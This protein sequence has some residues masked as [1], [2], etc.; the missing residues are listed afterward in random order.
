MKTKLIKLLTV[1]TLAVMC[2]CVA[3]VS[4]NAAAYYGDIDMDGN[5]S[6]SDA[7]KVL[8]HSAKIQLLDDSLFARA[9]VNLDKK[10]TASDAR[11]ILRVAAKLDEFEEY[12]DAVIDQ[13]ELAEYNGIKA[14]KLPY[15]IDGLKIESIVY[16]AEKSSIQMVVRNNTGYAVERLSYIT[17]KCYDPINVFINERTVSVHNMNKNEACLLTFYIHEDTAKIVFY[18]A[19]IKK[20]EFVPSSEMVEVDGMNVNKMPLNLNGIVI[21]SISFDK[22]YKKAEI[23][24]SNET[25]YPVSSL[26]TVLYKT[27]NSDGYIVTSKGIYL[28]EMN[29]NEKAI[30]SFY[31]DESVSDFVFYASDLRKSESLYQGEMVDIGGF[32]VNKMPY[33]L[34]GICLEN[35]VYNSK[36]KTLNVTLRNDH[37]FAISDYSYMEYKV[38]NAENFVVSSSNVYTTHL[39]SKESC[40]KSISL[41]EGA[42][43]VVFGNA[44][45]KETETLTSDKI[46]VYDGVEVT[47]LPYVTNGLRIEEVVFGDYNQIK[48]KIRNTTGNAITANSFINYKCYN[49][50][51]VVIRCGLFTTYTLNNNESQIYSAYLPENT[52]KIVFLNSTVKTGE[53][54]KNYAVS[55]VE[56]MLFNTCPVNINGL[57]IEKVTVAENSDC[58]YLTI[59][60]NTGK[61]LTNN[62]YILYNCYD[63]DGNVVKEGYAYL[64]RLNKYNETQVKIRVSDTAVKTVVFG[65]KIYSAEQ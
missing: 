21:N 4:A 28:E 34:N 33:S 18:K 20:C 7:R 27:Y 58:Y 40:L 1:I 16:D 10:I 35:A 54:K 57:T 61:N 26:S 48:I 5:V 29:N 41:P 64:D 52:A 47:S 51:G 49:P 19:D 15:E 3:A 13:I 8:R 59:V 60:N 11:L 25:G 37:S 44:K 2:L 23:V 32:S 22:K 39:N 17:Y 38:Y 55:N 31:Y 14:N 62:T 30:V 56:G 53:E 63:E 50:D 46:S 43:R 65:A 36:N 6:A 45:Y 24:V 9:D 12:E 42:T